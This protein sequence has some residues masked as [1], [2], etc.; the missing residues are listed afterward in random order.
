MLLNRLK[1]HVSLLS[2]HLKQLTKRAASDIIAI[3]INPLSVKLMKMNTVEEPYRLEYF[4]IA[5]TPIG[6]IVK[7]EIKNTEALGDLI[8]SMVK[9]SSTKTMTASFAIPRSLALVKNIAIDSRLN[10]DEI[11]SR[12]WL[13]AS[14]HF[15]DL[16]GEIYLDFTVVPSLV[17]DQ[18]QAELI[19]VA[20]RK[21]HIKPYLDTLQTAGLSAKV[22]EVNCYA[23]ERAIPLVLDKTQL[24]N[25]IA[26]LNLNV[27][28]SSLIVVHEGHLIY[29][30]DQSY[31]GLRLMTQ[32]NK[33]LTDKAN[34]KISEEG[35]KEPSSPV[36]ESVEYNAILR[37]N[38]ISHLRHAV[39]FFYSSRPNINIQKLIISGDCATIPG[40]V[41][42]IQKEL[43]MDTEL[44]NPLKHLTL[45]P[46]IDEKEIKTNAPTLMQC[47][48][49]ALNKY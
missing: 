8:K 49:L 26:V 22:V 16:I 21:E 37:E 11:E 25:T 35:N 5:P 1:E 17:P 30:H 12:A 13:E 6:A 10:S 34:L 24:L 33:Y 3:D 43:N 7:D 27:N 48:G 47:A 15:P 2:H 44:A 23:L 4:S 36:E 20:C 19:L 31:D 29:A 39:H 40:I 46:D 9:L 14:R 32:I 45:S 18:K 28:L 38:L 42:F 41:A